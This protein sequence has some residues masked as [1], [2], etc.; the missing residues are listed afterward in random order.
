[1][2]NTNSNTPNL[3]NRMSKQKYESINQS[4]SDDTRDEFLDDQERINKKINE[5]NKT[6][7]YK[8]RI[9]HTEINASLIFQ[10]VLHYNFYY[11]IL[12]FLIQIFSN[13]YKVN[14]T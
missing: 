14:K 9:I 5:M 7:L 4:E 1:M 6:N 13:S 3:K 2:R 10:S 12:N 8:S 11:A